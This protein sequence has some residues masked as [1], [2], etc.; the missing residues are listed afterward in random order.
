MTESLGSASLTLSANPAPLYGGLAAAKAKTLGMMRGTG[1]GSAAAFAAGMVTLGAAAG[2][3]LYKVGQQYQKAYNTIRV[4]TGATGDKLEKLKDTFKDVFGRTPADAETVS[5]ALSEVHRRTGLMGPP[6]EELT[7]QFLRLSGITGTDAQTNIK[8]VTRAF[9]DWGVATKDQGKTLD[10]FFALSQKTGIGV[11]TLATQ[12]AQFGTPLRAMG[13]S[14]ENAAAMFALFERSGVTVS[15]MMPGLRMALKNLAKPSEDLAARFKQL[16]ID[17]SKPEEALQKYMDAIKAAPDDV[18]AATLAMDLFGTRAGPDM[19][20]AIR[21]GKF[22]V[23]DLAKVMGNSSGAIESAATDAATLQGRLKILQHRGMNLLEPVAMKLTEA[24]TD[25]AGKLLD[26]SAWF[27]DLPEPVREVVGKVI[28][29]AGGLAILLSVVAKVRAAL[30]AMNATLLL[31]PYVAIAA[32]TI[33]VGYLIVKNWDKIKDFLAG[34]WDSIKSGIST[35]WRAIR[36][37]FRKNWKLLVAI[38]LGPMGLLVALIVKNWDKIKDLTGKAWRKVRDLVAVP[39]RAARRIVGDVAG[40]IRSVLSTIW[41][42]IV[43]RARSAWQAVRTA[44]TTPFRAAVSVVRAIASTIRSVVSTAWGVVRTVTRGAWNT[45]KTLILTPFSAAYNGVVVILGMLKTALSDT[46]AFVKKTVAS[47]WDSIKGL[48]GKALDKVNPFRAGVSSASVD[49][50]VAVS[51]AA[52]AAAYSSR[53]LSSAA[54]GATDGG[55]TVSVSIADGMGWLRDF[56]DVRI[57]ES[58][59]RSDRV[60]Q[61]GGL[62]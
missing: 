12:L 48:P 53:S 17:T 32:A 61:A 18:T 37:V 15:T 6:L 10:G 56:V 8:A 20:G 9:G 2:V 39:I 57:D 23:D 58:D 55:V 49:P 16:G 41:S 11:D 24:L 59:R 60:Y 14:I 4:E 33:A 51:P 26:L 47:I 43:S 62:V 42:A 25:L 44:I 40:T 50:N 30:A 7:L 31:N 52:S 1:A 54:T 28:M 45:V 13:F 22:E 3:V 29:F 46:W 35:A 5:K 19:A 34:V 21:E 27:Q 38:P 36:N